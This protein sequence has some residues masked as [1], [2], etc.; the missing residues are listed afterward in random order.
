MAGFL[1][2][3]PLR[4]GLPLNQFDHPLPRPR[5]PPP[6]LDRMCFSAEASFGVSAVLLPA[7]LY[8]VRAAA[9]KNP[10]YLPLALFP[11]LCSVQQFFE[12]LVWVGLGNDD[13]G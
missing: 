9:R 13:A 7:G 12:G 6:K 1:T 8:C 4:R 5:R 2:C 11:V 10:A 3:P